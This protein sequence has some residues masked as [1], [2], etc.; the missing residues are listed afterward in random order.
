MPYMDPGEDWY[1]KTYFD[2]GE[3]GLGLLAVSLE[4]LGDCPGNAKLLDAYYAGQDGT[5]VKI[6]NVFCVFEKYAGD[7]LWRHTEVGIPGR[8]VIK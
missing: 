6:S 2:A 3:F 8:T 5:P 1:Y 4:P 7:V